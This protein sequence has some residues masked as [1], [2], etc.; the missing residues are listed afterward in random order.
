MKKEPIVLVLAFAAVLGS[1]VLGVDAASP[2]S[3]SAQST[4]PEAWSFSSRWTRASSRNMA[5][6]SVCSKS[7]TA[8]S[9]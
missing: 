9:A 4:T 7:A 5:L 2:S 6:M 8:K 3:T 1:T